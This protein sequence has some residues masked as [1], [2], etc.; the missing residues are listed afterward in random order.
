M[1]WEWQNISFPFLHTRKR[2]ISNLSKENQT[3]N[4]IG[5]KERKFNLSLAKKLIIWMTES[6]NKNLIFK[7]RTREEGE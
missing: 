5:D 3:I 2:V 6:S 4:S 7:S 1:F